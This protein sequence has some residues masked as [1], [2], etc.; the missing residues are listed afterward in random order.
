M[1][2]ETPA[3]RKK[4]REQMPMYGGT[5]S[6]LDVLA[7]QLAQRAIEQGVDLVGPNGLLAE[8]TRRVLQAGLDAEMTSHLGHEW[9]AASAD[10]SGNS[11]KGYSAKTVTTDIGTV[12]LRIPRDRAGSFDPQMGADDAQGDRIGVGS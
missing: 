11:R 7:E 12:D 9:H 6:A 3:Q 4:R 1:P 5:P 8:L 2:K 10:G